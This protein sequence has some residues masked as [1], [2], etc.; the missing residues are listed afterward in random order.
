MSTNT[1]QTIVIDDL[2]DNDQT[3]TVMWYCGVK[4]NSNA[5][6][7][8]KVTVCFNHGWLFDDICFYDIGITHI[9][10]LQ[11]GTVWKRKRLFEDNPKFVEK[12][13]TISGKDGAW[14][15]VKTLSRDDSNDWLIPKNRYALP[16]AKNCYPAKMA[17]FTIDGNKN[18]LI[19]PCL[20]MFSRLYGH[21][22]HVKKSL[23]N[24]PLSMAETTLIYQDVVPQVPGTWLITLTKHCQNLDAVYLAHLKHDSVTKKRTD[25]IWNSL[26]FTHANSK[27]KIGFPSVPPW[28]SDTVEIK[29]KGI[30]LDNEK[31]RF[32][33]LRILGCSN[34]TGPEIFLD[35]ENTNLSE[36]TS[37]GGGTSV[38]HKRTTEETGTIIL[39]SEHEPGRNQEPVEVFNPD[40]EIIGDHREITQ[41]IRENKETGELRVLITDEEAT[42]HSGGDEHGAKLHVQ[43]VSI[44]TPVIQIPPTF[45]NVWHA[46]NKLVSKQVLQSVSC[47]DING[48]LI[49]SNETPGLIPLSTEGLNPKKEP[50]DRELYNWVMIDTDIGDKK[51][52]SVL[53]NKVTNVRGE[54]YLMEIERRISRGGVSPGSESDSYKGLVVQFHPNQATDGWFKKL[55]VALVQSK[56]VFT[57]ALKECEQPAQVATFKHVSDSKVDM[58][59]AVQNGLT[60]IGLL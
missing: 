10:L 31:T 41:V 45:M 58:E 24:Y 22:I 23:L 4:T 47:I 59:R 51:P 20:E 33:G 60:K 28:F 42:C 13:F 18:A 26:Q 12:M 3:L 46:L 57:N 5:P 30:W 14:D 40:F 2:P 19:I 54:C 9:G 50:K 15:I 34:S 27:D 38:I 7:E 36:S 44:N 49:G 39:T 6:S 29:V 56:G 21:S 11:I 1:N 35:R 32:L 16:D 53:L 25:L 52:R 55:L 48:Q 17:R 43:R 37:D 8:A